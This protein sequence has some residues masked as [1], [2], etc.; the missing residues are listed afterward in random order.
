MCEQVPSRTS[1]VVY[2]RASSCASE[3]RNTDVPLVGVR[4]PSL[5]GVRVPSLVGV[6]V[7][8]LASVPVSSKK[9]FC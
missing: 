7:S 5:A 3:R 2:E 1:T 4:V 9:V 6:R 8:S